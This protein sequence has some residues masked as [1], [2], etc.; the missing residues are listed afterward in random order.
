VTARS[1]ARPTDGDRLRSRQVQPRAART[2]C[3]AV[4]VLW[5]SRH[6]TYVESTPVHPIRGTEVVIPAMDSSVTWLRHR[7]QSWRSRLAGTTARGPRH[8]TEVSQRGNS[9]SPHERTA[10]ARLTT[11]VRAPGDRSA[12]APVLLKEDD[13]H[14]HAFVRSSVAIRR[15]EHYMKKSHGGKTEAAGYRQGLVGQ[16]RRICPHPRAPRSPRAIRAGDGN[17]RSHAPLSL[18]HPR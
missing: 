9:S 6:T 8:P 12:P 1:H 14:A 2:R 4:D 18:R 11:P 3:R 7:Q 17:V 15:T 16:M 13:L 10:T 5:P